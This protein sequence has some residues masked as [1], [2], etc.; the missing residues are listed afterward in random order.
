MIDPWKLALLLTAA[1]L[2]GGIPFGLLIARIKKIDIRRHGSGNVGATNVGRVL[3]KKWGILVLLLD[4]AKGAAPVLM[5]TYL[6]NRNAS[7]DGDIPQLSKDVLWLASGLTG[8]VGSMF[9]IYLAFR[10]GKGVAASL[11]VILAIFPYLTLPGAV[12]LVL[13]VATAAIWRYVSLAS[14]VAAVSLPI[15]FAVIA[16]FEGWPMKDHYPLL[17]LAALLALLVVMRHRANISR[18]LA[19]TENKLKSRSN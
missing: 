3:G 12:A 5:A 4:M 7:I 13:F 2:I 15:S 16:Q 1:Y 10:G 19:G 8:V 18:I 6:M 17:G 11:G 9:P 14:M